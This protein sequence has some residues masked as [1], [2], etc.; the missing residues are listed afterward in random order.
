MKKMI[1]FVAILTLV[2]FVGI[3]MAQQTTA[4][5]PTTT[6]PAPQKAKVEKPK[7]APKTQTFIGTVQSVDETRKTIVAK[8]AKGEKTFSISNA[9]ITKG[10][11][12]MPLS[13]LKEGTHVAIQYKDEAGT[14]VASSV[15]AADSKGGTAK[16]PLQRSSV[17]TTEEPDEPATK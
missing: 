15:K 1:L 12:G 14:M 11:K 7:A 4:P 16:A 17:K 6:A 3:V 13:E 2:A 8:N 5:A 9:E 10:G